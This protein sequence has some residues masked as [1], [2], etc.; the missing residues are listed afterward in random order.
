MGDGWVGDVHVVLALLAGQP[1]CTASE[2]LRT[3]GVTDDRMAG[4]H[5][6]MR[7]GPPAARLEDPSHPAMPAPACRALLGRAQGLAAARGA[8]SVGSEHALLA[9]VWKDDRQGAAGLEGLGTT[10]RAVLDALSSAG[11]TIPAVAPPEPDRREWGEPV[12][13]P[14]NRLNAVKAGLVRSL[15]PH[16][17]AGTSTATWRGW[18]RSPRSTSSASS[19]TS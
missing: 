8:R 18:W 15:P 2:A 4:S 16:D 7:E 5:R 17:W 13:F 3:C 1:D 10:A 9:W 14:I 19:T 11:V 6:A 12:V